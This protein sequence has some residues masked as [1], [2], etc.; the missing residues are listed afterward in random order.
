LN[1]RSIESDKSILLKRVENINGINFIGDIIDTGNPDYLKQLC[2]AIKKELKNY[3][4][5]LGADID[6]RPHV[7]TMIDDAVT[8]SKNLDAGKIIKEIV[9]PIIKGGGGVDRK[10]LQQQ[11]DR[12]QAICKK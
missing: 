7:V 5:V 8:L 1:A 3:L 2:F 4:I 11:A 12:M 9:A 10:R 6:R